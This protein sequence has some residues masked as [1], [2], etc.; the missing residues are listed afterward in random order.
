MGNCASDEKKAPAPQKQSPRQPPPHAAH[1]AAPTAQHKPHH[2]GA[3][4]VSFGCP[5]AKHGG[6]VGRGG[7]TIKRLEQNHRVNIVVGSKEQSVDHI[8]IEGAASDVEACRTEI[9][10]LLSFDLQR[11]PLHIYHFEVPK[12]KYGAIIGSG[13]S[14]LKEIEEISKAEVTVPPRGAPDSEKVTA[15]GSQ[16]ACQRAHEK[17]NAL[18]GHSVEVHKKCGTVQTVQEVP[19]ADLTK[20]VTTSLFFPDHDEGNGETTFAVFLK[21]L[22]APR[23]T[24]DIAIFTMTNDSIANAVM[25]CHRRGVTVRV[26]CDNDQAHSQGA[27]IHKLRQAGIEVRTDRK[28][29]HMHHKYVKN[30]LCIVLIPPFTL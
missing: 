22:N 17:I 6:I 20:Q 12:N 11:G 19:R 16:A 2:S 10:S 24:L 29:E 13:G 14:N 21:Y 9:A 15:M 7:A 5:A 25:D 18:L 3:S 26:V 28:S 30:V 1:T 23:H 27:D 8:V 4:S